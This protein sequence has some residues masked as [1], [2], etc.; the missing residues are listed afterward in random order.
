MSVPHSQAVSLL[1][2][3][4]V[5]SSLFSSSLHNPQIPVARWLFGCTTLVA[6]IVHVG[7]VTR[8]TKSGLSMTDWKPL[9]S[10]PPITPEEWET[11]FAR[12]RSFPEFAQRQSMTLEEFK[13]IFFW[14]WGH[15]MLGRTVG[16]CFAVPW[17]YYTSRGRIPRSFQPRLMCLFALGGAQGLV[18][19]WMVRS[20]LGEDRRGDRKEIRVSPYRLAT[21]LSVAATT[22]GVLGW[23]TLDMLHHVHR[24][25]VQALTKS[26]QSSETYQPLLRQAQRTRTGAVFVTGLTGLTL[27]SGAFVAGNDAGLAYNTFPKMTEDSWVPWEDLEDPGL[28]PKYRNVFENTALVQLNHR[29]LGVGTGTAALALAGVSLL[30][31]RAAL[32]PQA[33]RGLRLVGGVAAAQASLGV[34]TLLSYVPIEMAALHQVGSLALLSSGTYLV[35]SLR[36]VRPAALS[37]SSQQL[38]R[39]SSS[40]IGRTMKPAL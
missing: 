8:L 35:H 39:N 21:H 3:Q 40:V 12:Y 1:L 15:R 34:A 28:L 14:E 4:G 9:G 16:V 23:T 19:W 31:H 33:Q 38:L 26:L 30:R 37:L 7:G 22:F 17:L 25:K 32:T 20:G 18:G 24:D 2:K 5:P 29:I 36:Y 10:L 11:E 13:Y 6:G 27:A